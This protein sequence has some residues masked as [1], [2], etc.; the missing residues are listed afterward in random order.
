MVRGRLAVLVI[1][2]QRRFHTRHGLASLTFVSSCG[3]K[4]RV[5]QTFPAWFRRFRV[6]ASAVASLS[7]KER[8]FK[9]RAKPQ[10]HPG[11]NMKRR[12]LSKFPP[13]FWNAIVFGP[14]APGHPGCFH[15]PSAVVEFRLFSMTSSGRVLFCSRY[16]LCEI[17]GVLSGQC[18]VP[19]K[20]H[21]MKS[22]NDTKSRGR[23]GVLRR[24]P[25]PPS[26]QRVGP[27][28]PRGRAPVRHPGVSIS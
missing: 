3:L 19:Q 20:T 15:L 26:L 14:P 22:G 27:D 1:F 25:P 8:C 9:K 11:G 18:W 21:A 4:H 7:D 6:G 12:I 17:A 24:E 16:A 2:G 23:L 28:A 13:C 5:P 10:G